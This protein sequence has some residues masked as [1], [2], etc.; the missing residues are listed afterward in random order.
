M[1]SFVKFTTIMLFSALMYLV[2]GVA[3]AKT[4][5]VSDNLTITLRTGPGNQFQI[6]KSLD[7]GT[8]LEVLENDEASGWSKVKTG[9]D[10]EGWVLTR[11]LIDEPINKV[12]LIAAEKR[13]ARYQTEN[14]TLKDELQALQQA[15][16]ELE[17]EWKTLSTESTKMNKELSRVRE[18]SAQP[19]KM[20]DE[21]KQLKTQSV[22]LE[23]E[24]K[25]LTQ[26]NQALKDR[27]NRD[28]FIAGAAVL[29]FGLVIG[30]IIPKIRW[31]K[32]SGWG[33]SL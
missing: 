14:A 27:T 5:Y 12:K 25:M 7:S 24:V 13:L 15:K 8:A 1:A 21:N 23:N 11:Y 16:N 33:D 10:L 2:S 17:K 26:E 4:S 9:T 18:I 29:V 3:L 30:L 22:A 6:R 20:A 19:L 31:N 32:K 28:W